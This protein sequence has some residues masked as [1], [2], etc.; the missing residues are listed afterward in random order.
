MYHMNSCLLGF[1]SWGGIFALDLLE[2]P[3]G[4]TI[5]GLDRYFR[6]NKRV[7]YIRITKYLVYIRY[8]RKNNV[9]S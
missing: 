7:R 4:N 3:L 5:E 1:G 9:T 6:Q 8:L 2:E